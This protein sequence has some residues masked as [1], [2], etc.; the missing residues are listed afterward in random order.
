MFRF[1]TY[2]DG[3]YGAGRYVLRQQ[4]SGHRQRRGG[5]CDVATSPWPSQGADSEPG[6]TSMQLL[7]RYDVSYVATDVG[8][9]MALPAFGP[10]LLVVGVVIYVIRRDRRANPE[11]LDGVEVTSEEGTDVK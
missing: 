6:N 11:V 2:G 1:A 3:T 7:A 5:H 10:A 8:L 4:I 9:W